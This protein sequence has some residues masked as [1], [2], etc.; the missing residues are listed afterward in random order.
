MAG[1]V[2]VLPKIACMWIL[3]PLCSYLIVTH[4]ANLK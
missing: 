4:I 2:H 1:F 3:S